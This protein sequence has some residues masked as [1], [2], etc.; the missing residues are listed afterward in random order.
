MDLDSNE[1]GSPDR[2]SQRRSLVRR[3]TSDDM[4]DKKKLGKKEPFGMSKQRVGGGRLA[5]DLV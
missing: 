2:V 4:M 1:A 3:Y 5:T